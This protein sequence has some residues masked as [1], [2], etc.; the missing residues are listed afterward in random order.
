MSVS[1]W[2]LEDIVLALSIFAIGVLLGGVATLYLPSQPSAGTSQVPWVIS[3]IALPI[4]VALVS[5]YFSIH[6]QFEKKRE[7]RIEQE[8][9]QW[10]VKTVSILQQIYLVC[11]QL[12]SNEPVEDREEL[13]NLD[14]LMSKLMEHYVE[15]PGE[16]DRDIAELVFKIQRNYRD[17][18]ADNLNTDH[19]RGEF[20]EQVD[21]TLGQVGKESTRINEE[22][23]PLYR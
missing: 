20:S 18:D 14:S 11:T 3:G 5:S 22:N 7:E 6:I 9:E 2:T 16:I 4:L 15:A 1:N 21:S 12:E 8:K 13:Q 19:F 17:P 10:L 23:L